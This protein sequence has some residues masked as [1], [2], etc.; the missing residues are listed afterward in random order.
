MSGLEPGARP[1]SNGLCGSC[2]HARVVRSAK[3]GAFSRCELSVRDERFPKYPRLPV[4]VTSG[5]S[6]ATIF[7]EFGVDR[8]DGVIEKPATRD[9]IA[10]ILARVVERPRRR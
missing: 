7:E 1:V 2:R 6:E 10:A 5:W 4:I 8:P 3:G 9:K